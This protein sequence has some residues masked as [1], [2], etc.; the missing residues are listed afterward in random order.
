MSN[1]G[2]QLSRNQIK[3]IEI[4]AFEGATQREV[5]TRLELHENTITNWKKDNQF[6]RELDK[7]NRQSINAASSKALGVMLSLL[8]AD[9][10][11]VQ[12]NAAKDILDRAGYKPS[13]NVNL[14]VQPRTDKL[15]D[16]LR[17]LGGKGLED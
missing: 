6:I 5:A 14:G 11:M 16:I 13:D 10:E 1:K 8:K 17:Q 3:A 7:A 9:S 4:L 2:K 15:D 12:Y